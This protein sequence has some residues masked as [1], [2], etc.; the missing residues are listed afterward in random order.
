MRVVPCSTSF[1]PTSN[2][3]SARRNT[4]SLLTS[5][6]SGFAGR[7]R[8]DVIFG[9]ETVLH[10]AILHVDHFMLVQ[11]THRSGYVFLGSAHGEDDSARLHGLAVHFRFML[12][13]VAAKQAVPK[14]GLAQ[15]SA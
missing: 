2:C 1:F 6:V 8:Y 15:R 9:K 3:S 7:R 14:A 13:N 4:C 12:L 10:G 5:V 11:D